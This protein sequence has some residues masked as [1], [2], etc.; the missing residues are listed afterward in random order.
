MGFSWFV[1]GFARKELT[2]E[3]EDLDAW[4][5]AEVSQWSIDEVCVFFVAWN[6]RK[7]SP[8]VLLFGPSDVLL[9]LDSYRL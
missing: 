4:G 6:S 3:D 2:A 1:H 7:I 9:V 5:G 8:C